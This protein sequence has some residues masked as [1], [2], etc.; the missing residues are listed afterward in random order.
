MAG[1]FCVSLTHARDD[2]DK[3]TV[4]FVI[5]NAAVGSD[6]ETVVFL[7]TEG[8][9]LAVEGAADDIHEEGFAPLKEL[10]DN[11]VGAGGTILVCSPCFN[12]RALDENALVKGAKIVG[13]AKLV[14]F[15]A[16]GTPSVSY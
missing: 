7:S 13:G 2:T 10:M 6:Q 15:L 11:F 14:E 1:K 4:A 16:D 3:A 8:V 12:K 5:A 9:N